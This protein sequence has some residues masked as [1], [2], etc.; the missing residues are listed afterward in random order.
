MK[1][2]F[3]ITLSGETFEVSS[4]FAVVERIEQRFDMMSFLR[5]IQ[6]YRAKMSHIAWVIFCATVEAG[7]DK[8]YTDIGELVQNDFQGGVSSAS[9]VVENALNT[10]PEKMPKKKEAQETE[11]SLGSESTTG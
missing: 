11:E 1:R 8:T 3:E 5:S 4:T 6:S 9:S 10:G 7:Y 2:K